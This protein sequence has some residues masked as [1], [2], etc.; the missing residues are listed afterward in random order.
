MIIKANFILQPLL[1]IQSV[2]LSE[3]IVK[4]KPV[5]MVQETVSKSNMN[6]YSAINRKDSGF[7]VDP[8]GR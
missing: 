1:F 4:I 3:K 5:K 8:A 2:L 7:V 6:A